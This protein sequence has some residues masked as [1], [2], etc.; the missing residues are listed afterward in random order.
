MPSDAS[1]GDGITMPSVSSKKSLHSLDHTANFID[2]WLQ[3]FDDNY[4]NRISIY[5]SKMSE[6][7]ETTPKSLPPK[8]R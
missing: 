1:S 4:Q 5:K 6:L 2:G 8:K 3:C 7:F